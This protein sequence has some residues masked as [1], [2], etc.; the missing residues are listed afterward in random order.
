M[1]VAKSPCVVSLYKDKRPY[2]AVQSASLVFKTPTQMT[3]AWDPSTGRSVTQDELSALLSAAG[4]SAFM[5]AP[6]SA[7]PDAVC[8][9]L[10]FAGEQTVDEFYTV[11][12]HAAA[13]RV[14]SFLSMISDTS[15][16]VVMQ[17]GELAAMVCLHS[18]LR[19]YATS[20]MARG[21]ASATKTAPGMV[22]FPPDQISQWAVRMCTMFYSHRAI[23][24]ASENLKNIG[25]ARLTTTTDQVPETPATFEWGG[26]PTVP[27]GPVAHQFASPVGYA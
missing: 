9:K 5:P 6:A 7:N 25:R 1:A 26:A 23:Q 8:I 27:H 10:V 24:H 14:C 19:S 20:W 11:D 2:L 22:T 21:L 13:S 4:G 3:T 16:H 18:N 15:S 12:I 17:Q